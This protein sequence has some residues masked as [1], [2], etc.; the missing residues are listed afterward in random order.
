M[1]KGPHLKK[2]LLKKKA[3]KK[4]KKILNKN[5]IFLKVF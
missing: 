5:V 4:E 2:C 1:Y 3:M